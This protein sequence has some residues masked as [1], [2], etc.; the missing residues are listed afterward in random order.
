MQTVS[1]FVLLALLL[2]FVGAARRS[3]RRRH[4]GSGAGGMVYDLLNQD[5]RNALE[6]IVEEK[7]E[8]RDAEDADG[9]LPEL[10]RPSGPVL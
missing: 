8:A 5:R 3:R 10:E 1:F 9:N 7:A 6:L 4:A 2:L